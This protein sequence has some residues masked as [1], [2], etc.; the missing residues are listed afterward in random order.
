MQIL[1]RQRLVMNNLVA[2]LGLF[3]IFYDSISGNL[4]EG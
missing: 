4:D 1:R 3:Y 2:N